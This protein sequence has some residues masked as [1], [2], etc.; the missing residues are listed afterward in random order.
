MGISYEIIPIKD[1]YNSYLKS[2]SQLL[3]QNNVELAHE[4]IQARIRGNLLMAYANKQNA[5]LLAT[6]NKSE[7]AVGYTTLYGDMAGGLAPIADLY[8]TQIYAL[9]TYI[10][11]MG[12]NPDFV[13]DAER[14]QKV[15]PV[16][17]MEKAP[18]AELRPDQ[19]DS[20]S[21]PDYQILDF[22]LQKYIEQLL[23][24][25]EIS[26][27]LQSAFSLSAADSY[28]IVE[29]TIRKI[30]FSEHKRK[31]ATITLKVSER[32]FTLG[33]RFPITQ[34]FHLMK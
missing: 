11:T 30:H 27:E 10:N 15:I 18:S 25:S 23:P 28:R 7:S 33:W 34:R 6:S 21:L 26:T 2:L 13:K 22:V 24:A 14:F 9:G 3:D 19:K 32:D 20:D 5:L 4:N 17:I 1:I 31:Q 16:E 29:E 8:K 12:G